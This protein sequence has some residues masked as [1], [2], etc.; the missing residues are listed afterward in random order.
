MRKVFLGKSLLSKFKNAGGQ[1]QIEAAKFGCK[2]YH[3]RYVYN[4]EEVYELFKKEYLKY[5]F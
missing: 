1:N 5:D 3:G 2:I 4:F